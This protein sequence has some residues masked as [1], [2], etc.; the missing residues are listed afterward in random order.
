[1]PRALALVVVAGLLLAPAS[2]PAATKCST[3]G[4]R[5][6]RESGS[7][8]RSTKVSKLQVRGTSCRTARRVAATVAKA[9]L[10]TNKVPAR[11]A[12]YRILANKPCA[13]CAPVWIVR[14]TKGRR[15]V[16]FQVR[17]GA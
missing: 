9:I 7:S 17:G 1:M 5:Y 8:T 6:E 12:T 11:A 4:M 15:I 16:A 10:R 3:K 13:G 2:A 14:G